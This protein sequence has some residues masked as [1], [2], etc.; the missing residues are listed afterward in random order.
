MQWL[1][2]AIPFIICCS[3]VCCALCVGLAFGKG[4]DVDKEDHPARLCG[5]CF[6]LITQITCSVLVIIT[7]VW[8]ATAKCIDPD[9]I[10]CE[11]A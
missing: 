7:I 3:G 9:G 6:G 4:E 5:K 11:G 1:I 10:R 2:R 8:V